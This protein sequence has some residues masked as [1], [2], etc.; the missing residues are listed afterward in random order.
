LE[1][2][3]LFVLKGSELPRKCASGKAACSHCGVGSLISVSSGLR[4]EPTHRLGRA[5][6]ANAFYPDRLC[7]GEFP[8][9]FFQPA[10]R[11]L[12]SLS[13]FGIELR[14]LLAQL[15]RSEQSADLLQ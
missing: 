4:E 11:F 2:V 13:L 5:E 14:S 12:P 3:R 1:W 6:Q 8:L 7:R 15:V 9:A 10:P